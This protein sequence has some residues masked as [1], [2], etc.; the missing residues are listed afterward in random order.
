MILRPLTSTDLPALH[1][2]MKV[3]YQNFAH[4]LAE[5]TAWFAGYSGLALGLFD[6]DELIGFAL[7]RRDAPFLRLEDVGL[8]PTRRTPSLARAGL[9]LARSWAREEGLTGLKVQ[10]CVK[11]L[12]ALDLLI[13]GGLTISGAAPGRTKELRVELTGGVE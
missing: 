9:D 5:V 7:G 4:S 3:N 11:D 1:E 2:V 13:K 6:E 8:I 12:L 10:T